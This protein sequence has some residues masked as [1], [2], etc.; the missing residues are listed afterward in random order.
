[1]NNKK[2]HNI[3]MSYILERCAGERSIL[4]NN[5]IL[6]LSTWIFGKIITKGK[7]HFVIHL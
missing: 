5:C 1:M 2:E 7:E 4:R 6:L 3:L